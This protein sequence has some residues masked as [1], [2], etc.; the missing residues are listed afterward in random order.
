MK[1]GGAEDIEAWVI[2]LYDAEGEPPD[3]NFCKGFRDNYNLT[4]TRVLYDPWLA[5]TIY[6][7][8][9]T[10]I[11]SN[12]AGQ[13]VSKHHS[14]AL[15]AIMK[16]IEDELEA[17]PGQCST[18]AICAEEEFCLPTPTDDG[19]ACTTLCDN[20]DPVPCPEEGDVCY[21][22]KEGNTNGACFSPDMLP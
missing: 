3:A 14:D 5:S 18:P 21:I 16:V 13:I 8:K 4:G 10:S 19:K 2:I 6:G 9:E 7:D 1:D 20:A 15:A 11:I 17:G 22:Y 12:E